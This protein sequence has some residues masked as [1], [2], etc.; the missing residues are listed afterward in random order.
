MSSYNK[1]ARGENE[2]G[3]EFSERGYAWMRAPGSGTAQRELPDVVVGNGE[4]MYAF[5][6]KRW[7]NEEDYQ[8]LSKKE[9]NDL[10]F[11]ANKFGM[12]YFISVRF[13][14]G[15]W[16]FFKK[17]ELHETDKSLRV[18]KFKDPG[19]KGFGRVCH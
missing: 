11:F 13:D 19:S 4:N 10:Q 17:E 12:E 18:D 16:G 9:V 7:G 15:S 3:D 6:V 5:E 8:Y 2:L 1:G 14:H